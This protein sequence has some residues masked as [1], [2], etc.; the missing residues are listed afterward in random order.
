[1]EPDAASE[2]TETAALAPETVPVKTKAYLVEPYVKPIE[3]DAAVG[4]L[5][6][7]LRTS[8][9]FRKKPHLKHLR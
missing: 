9:G 7:Y 1:M 5:G 2:N 4:I 6:G 8:I 3:S